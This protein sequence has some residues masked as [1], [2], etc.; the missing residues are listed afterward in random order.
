M[1]DMGELS[2]ED[3]LRDELR[4]VRHDLEHVTAERNAAERERDWAREERDLLAAELASTGVGEYIVANQKLAREVQ[5]LQDR[6]AK[7]REICNDRRAESAFGSWADVEEIWPSE[8]L[9][10][11]DGR[12]WHA[13]EDGDLEDSTEDAAYDNKETGS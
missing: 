13:D 4:R 11:L 8:I 2:V 6:I 7:L 5:A 12:D 3:Q 1:T 9:A 10:V